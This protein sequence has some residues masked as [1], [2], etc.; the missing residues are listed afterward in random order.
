MENEEKSDLFSVYFSSVFTL[1][2]G[3]PLSI[4]HVCPPLVNR[5]DFSPLSVFKAL[6]KLKGKRSLG[7][8]G[9]PSLFFKKLAAPLAFPLSLIMQHSLVTGSLPNLWK[10]AVVIPIF[11]NK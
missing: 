10:T 1:D 5:V 9:I 6:C 2:N 11:K 3:T 4:N 7:P 8:E